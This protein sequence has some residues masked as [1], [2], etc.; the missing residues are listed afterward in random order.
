MPNVKLTRDENGKLTITPEKPISRV[1]IDNISRIKSCYTEH[2]GECVSHYFLFTDGSKAKY[3]IKNDGSY[4]L[5][6]EGDEGKDFT[7]RLDN[8]Y[9]LHIGPK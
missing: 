5:S 1:G 7:T 8:E 4:S 9:I 6:G 3:T 2:D